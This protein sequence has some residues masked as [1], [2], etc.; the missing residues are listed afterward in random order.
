M[1]IKFPKLKEVAETPETG[2][3]MYRGSKVRAVRKGEGMFK[4]GIMKEI[5]ME[6]SK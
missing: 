3:E 5:G 6:K 2:E 1:P 4:R